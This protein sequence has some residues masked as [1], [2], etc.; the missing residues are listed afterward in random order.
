MGDEKIDP[1]NLK[2][3]FRIYDRDNDGFITINEL[4]NAMKSLGYETGNEELQELIKE[5][6]KDENGN[7]DVD[8][9][10][11]LINKRIEEAQAEKELIETFN[12]FDREG[13]GF[14]KKDELLNM[15]DRFAVEIDEKLL[16]DFYGQIEGEKMNCEQF[17][18]LLK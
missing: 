16:D 5:F 6:D 2:E 17:I 10:V 3:I 4:G 11:E 15:F 8:E 14:L 7:L 12:T 9:F 13:K 18:K 1:A